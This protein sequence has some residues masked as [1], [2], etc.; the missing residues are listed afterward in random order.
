MEK[1]AREYI[2][3]L[4]T[5]Y[6]ICYTIFYLYMLNHRGT[7]LKNNP[8]SRRNPVAD[9]IRVSPVA[10]SRKKIALRRILLNNKPGKLLGFQVSIYPFLWQNDGSESKRKNLLP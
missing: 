4:H 10:M 2:S 9:R 1:E 5:L 6:I 8:H 7:S 3:F